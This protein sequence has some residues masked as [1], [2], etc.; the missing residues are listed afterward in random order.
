MQVDN[1]QSLRGIKRS[2][3]DVKIYE[4]QRVRNRRDLI[5]FVFGLKLQYVQKI[6]VVCN[7]QQ[8]TKQ[9]QSCEAT[10]EPYQPL[11]SSIIPEKV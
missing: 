4:F 9:G 3:S 11:L 1:L 2:I 7:I 5:G 6:G 10:D 8:G